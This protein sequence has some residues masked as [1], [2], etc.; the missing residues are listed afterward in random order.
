M[1][2]KYALFHCKISLTNLLINLSKKKLPV[3]VLRLFQV[4]GLKQDSNRIIPF[5]IKIVL[6]TGSSNYKRF[7]TLRFL[8][9]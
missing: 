9:R 3:T 1:Q 5:L 2:S 6:R 7:A 4:Y 8:S